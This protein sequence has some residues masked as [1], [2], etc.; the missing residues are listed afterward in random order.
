M[1]KQSLLFVI[2]LALLTG[3][4][5]LKADPVQLASWTFES[6][7]S[8]ANNVYTPNG[9]AWAEVSAQWFNAGQP[10]FVADGVA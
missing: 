9:E 3:W 10:Q 2:L 7:Y 8:V 6:G 1:K 5:P 4:Q